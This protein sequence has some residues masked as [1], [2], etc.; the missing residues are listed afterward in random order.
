MDYGKLAYLKTEDLSKRITNL[1]KEK[2]SSLKSIRL[3]EGVRT[4]IEGI[5]E[6]TV[7][8]SASGKHNVVTVMGKLKL[9]HESATRVC[10]K[11]YIN[12]HLCY[13]DESNVLQGV[14]DYL[15]FANASVLQGGNNYLKIQIGQA[16]Y[17][18]ELESYDIIVWGEG[19]DSHEKDSSIDVCYEKG[20]YYVAA[21][22]GG[23]AY[24]WRSNGEIDISS[25]PY[26][27]G[28]ADSVSI[29]S[30]IGEEISLYYCLSS[31]GRLK[32]GRLGSNEVAL[33]QEHEVISAAITKTSTQ[34]V[35]S[36]IDG[37][38][39][40]YRIFLPNLSYLEKV[41]LQLPSSFI[42]TVTK[43][44]D[45]PVPMFLYKSSDNRLYVKSALPELSTNADAKPIGIEVVTYMT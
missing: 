45:S 13:Q 19:V 9:S 18:G 39:A 2:I 35:V 17:K 8:F 28:E 7:S 5:W 1:E 22:I 20:F 26:N 23:K 24:V 27:L 10:I 14:Q 34:F 43:V 38:K 31:G 30:G 12:E 3:G 41:E 33:P 36:Y 16:G 15:V 29:C 25:P 21:V 42:E 32:V 37:L 6:N 11:L 44:A 40:Y 4:K